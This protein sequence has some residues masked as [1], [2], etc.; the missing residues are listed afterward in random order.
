MDIKFLKTKLLTL[1][2]CDDDWTDL[3]AIVCFVKEF[4][5]YKDLDLIKKTTLEIIK[6]LLEEKLVLA[7][8]LLKG[9]KFGIW[10]KNNDE[11]ITEIKNKWDN[12]DRQLYPHEIVWFEITEKGRKEFEYLNS[13]PELRETDPFYL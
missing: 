8:E 3:H 11:I 1:T 5:H 6:N 13:L 12:L 4:Y 10:N 9:N 7:G 2:W